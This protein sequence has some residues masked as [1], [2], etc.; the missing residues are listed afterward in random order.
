[1]IVVYRMK[2]SNP[3]AKVG[4]TIPW[5]SKKAAICCDILKKQYL[6]VFLKEVIFLQPKIQVGEI[7]LF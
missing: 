1:M 6:V 4:I 2:L 3:S 7:W 5:Y